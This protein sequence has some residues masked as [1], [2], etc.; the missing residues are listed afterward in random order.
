M[1]GMVGMVAIARYWIRK[2]AALKVA[3]QFTST[4]GF[5]ESIANATNISITLAEHQMTY[6]FLWPCHTYTSDI[7]IE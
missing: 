3:F 2:Q 1:Y 5:I 6:R 7:N 4:V